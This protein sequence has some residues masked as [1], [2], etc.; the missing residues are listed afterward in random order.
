[1]RVATDMK[2]RGVKTIGLI[3][4]ADAY[5]EVWF[6][7]VTRAAHQHGIEV[8]DTERYAR[9]DTSVTAQ[10]LRL[11]AATPDSIFVAAS[12]TPAALPQTTLVERGFAGTI[13]QTSGI[14]N[15]DFLRVAGSSSQGVRFA[16]GGFLVADQLAPGD[17]VRAVAHGFRT[18]YE[19]AYGPGSASVFA[20]NANDALVVLMRAL[21]AAL[22]AGPPQTT[23]FRVALRDTIEGTHG[24]VTCEGTLNLSPS[25]HAGYDQ[26]S[27]H[28]IEIRDGE[29][30]LVP[31]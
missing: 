12:G 3:G 19:A 15:Q 23:A 20:A 29:W 26:A 11:M 24:V 16:A 2:L 9:T 22:A 1:V 7:A 21:P 14:A 18:R 6:D 31:P 17:P 25:D 10:V 27:I 5:G 30:R 13:Y 28:M 4:F 8:V